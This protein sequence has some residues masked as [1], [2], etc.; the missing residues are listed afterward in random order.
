MYDWRAPG[1]VGFRW[2]DT[3]RELGWASEFDDLVL[4]NIAGR[5]SPVNTL[6]MN[7]N[8]SVI[9]K[10]LGC[11]TKEGPAVRTSALT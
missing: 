9:S 3:G 5:E 10:A 11:T 8:A 6:K 7:K 1:K 4:V 2:D